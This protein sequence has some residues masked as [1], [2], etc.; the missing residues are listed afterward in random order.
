MPT[1]TL[2]GHDLADLL[3]TS[4]RLSPHPHIVGDR[5]K[6]TVHTVDGSGVDVADLSD[7][8]ILAMIEAFTDAD[9]TV[10]TFSLDDVGMSYVLKANITRIDVG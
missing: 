4:G 3:T 5:V 7:D 8:S 10:M 1:R 2:T 6:V 9:I